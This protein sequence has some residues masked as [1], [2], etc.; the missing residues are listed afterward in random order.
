MEWR[1]MCEALLISLIINWTCV[2]IYLH[3]GFDAFMMHWWH[4]FEV[5]ATGWH[6]INAAI[7]FAVH[8]YHPNTYNSIEEEHALLLVCYSHLSRARALWCLCLTSFH[9]NFPGQTFVCV[10]IFWGWEKWQTDASPVYSGDSEMAGTK[11]RR[12]KWKLANQ[13]SVRS[14]NAPTK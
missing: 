14:Y 10:N 12:R 2:M 8:C 1:R 6:T 5:S 7:L 9:L 4:I 11:V 3:F 13:E